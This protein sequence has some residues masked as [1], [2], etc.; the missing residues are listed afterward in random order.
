MPFVIS[1]R[2]PLPAP[3][4]LA[5][6]RRRPAR[7]GLCLGRPRGGPMGGAA[8]EPPVSALASSRPQSPARCQ[9]LAAT[10]SRLPA[11]YLILTGLVPHPT[12][13][14]LGSSEDAV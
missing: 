7:L 14:G 1:G 2:P 9:V 13:R 4:A 11:M 5:R 12:P 8:V 6:V 10:R 3:L